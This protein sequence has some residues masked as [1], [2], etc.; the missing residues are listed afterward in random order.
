VTAPKLAFILGAPRSGTTLLAR[1]LNAHSQIY[2][3]PEAHWL[4]PLAH[5]GLVDTVD[6]APY[7]PVQTARG[8][9]AWVRT[10]PGGEAT[11]F[12]A[13]RRASDHLY[14]ALANH[15][16]VP[17]IVDK[18]PAYT[19]I[20]PF[21]RR[22]YPDATFLVVTRHPAAIWHSYARTFFLGDWAAA[23]RH[24]P[25]LQ[26]YLPPLSALL[27]SP[28]SLRVHRVSFEELVTAPDQVL[29]PVCAALGVPFEPDMVHYGSGPRPEQGLGDPVTVD[30]EDRPRASYADAWMDAFAHHPERRDAI[31]RMLLAVSDDDLDTWGTPRSALWQGLT[32]DVART[33]RTARLPLRLVIERATVMALRRGARHRPLRTAL[34]GVRQAL[35]AVLRDA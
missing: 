29:A 5:L 23:E 1:L 33:R 32:E 11:Y 25:I 12:E 4:T 30:R 27:R 7:D 34:D 22:L 24:Q 20:L 6:Q 15:H 18:T 16:D 8:Q 10:L 28:G 31:E 14:G 21:I 19:L 26:R 13:L 35:N 2:A 17:L 3:G 9:R